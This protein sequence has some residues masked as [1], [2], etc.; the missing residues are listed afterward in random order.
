MARNKKFLLQFQTDNGTFYKIEVFDNDSSDSTQY[1]PNL[2]AD[3][4]K[5]YLFQCDLGLC[6]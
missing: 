2:G 5:L 3:G 6:I 1:T 4:F